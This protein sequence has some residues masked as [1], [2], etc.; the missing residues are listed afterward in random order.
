MLRLFSLL[1]AFTTISAQASDSITSSCLQM[2]SNRDCSVFN[3]CCDFRC[4][5]QPAMRAP[6]ESHFCLSLLGRIAA[7]RT[8]CVCN[9]APSRH[10]HPKFGLPYC[11]IVGGVI[12]IFVLDFLLLT[13]AL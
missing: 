12:L 3:R 10:K 6:G 7:D 9:S 1:L 2:A 4:R 11:D 5:Q 13:F 8:R